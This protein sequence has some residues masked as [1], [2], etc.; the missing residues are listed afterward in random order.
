MVA[1]Q[2]MDDIKVYHFAPER[3]RVLFARMFATQ[4]AFTAVFGAV[5][6]SWHASHGW[7]ALPSVWVPLAALLAIMVLLQLRTTT[8][9]VRQAMTY[10]LT[11]GPNVLRM[12]GQGLVTTEVLRPNATRIVESARG[13]RVFEGRSYVV[14]PRTLGGYGE[15]RAH[16]GAW[17]GIERS[18]LGHLW[19]AVVALQLTL[20]LLPTLLPMGALAASAVNGAFIAVS[21]A[22]FVMTARSMLSRPGKARIY[23][24][25]ILLVAWAALRIY[26]AWR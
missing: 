7:L 5:L 6:V 25:E 20:W 9:A 19:T 12:A 18:R 8:R 21:A 17:R 4:L 10:Q 26:L 3:R 23:A 22:L 11:V 2:V 16:V 15:I 14:V 24:L 1:S 13:L